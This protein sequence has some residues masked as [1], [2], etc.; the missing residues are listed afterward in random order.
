[1]RRPCG[2][3]TRTSPGLQGRVSEDKKGEE[4]PMG[5]WSASPE[6]FLQEGFR[7]ETTR[8]HR[9]PSHC[10]PGHHHGC[11]LDHSQHPPW[12]P[13]LSSD[14][15]TLHQ[16]R[17]LSD[18]R[19]TGQEVQ[20]R[21]A[22]A[23]PR[24]APGLPCGQRRCQRHWTQDLPGRQDAHEQC[25]GQRGPGTEHC[26]GEWDGRL[27]P[28]EPLEGR[29]CLAILGV[30]G[31]LIEARAFDMWAGDVND[32]L[33]FI[34]PLHEGTLVFV[35]SYDDPATK[36][37]EETRKLFSDLGSKNVKDLAFRDSWVFVGAKG[38][39]NKSPFEQHVKNSKH[40]NKYEGWPEAL[41]MEGCIPRRPAAS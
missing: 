1:M 28:G 23:M 14:P 7:L 32:L 25:Q 16:P 33:K 17:E 19:T 8:P 24:G 12:W 30:N 35:A 5:F 37:N 15:A 39:Q 36:M 13:W 18:C 27:L 3:G 11:H 4:H 2:T 29:Q 6:A 9:P 26:P 20:M 41:E 10:G 34:R 31:D 21:S 40:T 38:V 22:P